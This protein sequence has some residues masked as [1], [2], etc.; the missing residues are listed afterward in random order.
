MRPTSSSPSSGAKNH[1]ENGE[2]IDFAS[3]KANLRGNGD[4][5]ESI[6]QM[7][8]NGEITEDEYTAYVEY[9]GYD[10]RYDES[11]S[12]PAEASSPRFKFESDG[13]QLNAYSLGVTIFIAVGLAIFFCGVAFKLPG[14]C[15]VGVVAVALS[16]LMSVFHYRSNAEAER[17]RRDKA[18][19]KEVESFKLDLYKTLVGYD[20][21]VNQDE[22][23]ALIEQYR[24][25]R[26]ASETSLIALNPF[27]MIKLAISKTKDTN[28]STGKEKKKSRRPK[29]KNR[30]KEEQ[31]AMSDAISGMS[32]EE[33]IEAATC[34]RPDADGD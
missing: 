13:I 15:V 1:N 2:V 14:L 33:I 34:Q 24:M 21:H 26:I 8:E 18:V 9:Y 3:A 23:D 30:K 16:I 5:P 6:I 12:E 4:S 20:L 17:R 31:Q 28:G 7:L 27:E 10:P 19:E 22:I 25:D 32:D 29:R 11:S